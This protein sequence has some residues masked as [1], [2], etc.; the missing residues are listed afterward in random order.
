[1]QSYCVLKNIPKPTNL[2]SELLPVN[3]RRG[4]NTRQALGSRFTLPLP[5][6][7]ALKKTLM[8]RAVAY[9]NKLPSQLILMGNKSNLKRKLKKNC[10]Q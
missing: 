5:R 9:W 3:N 2:F 8:Y 7:N 10:H 1:M 4:Y 6:T